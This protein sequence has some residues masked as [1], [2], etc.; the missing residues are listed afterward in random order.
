[1]FHPPLVLHLASSKSIAGETQT[2]VHMKT[3]KLIKIIDNLDNKPNLPISNNGIKVTV[4]AQLYYLHR[5][6]QSTQTARIRHT[7]TMLN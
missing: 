4:L 3:N 2:K 6:E 5:I 1:L 7:N